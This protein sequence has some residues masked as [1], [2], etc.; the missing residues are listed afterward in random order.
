[1]AQGQRQIETSNKGSGFEVP[2]SPIGV[3]KV[4]SVGTTVTDLDGNDQE[5]LVCNLYS[6]DNDVTGLTDIAVRASSPG[7]HEVGDKIF[8]FRPDGGTGLTW[9]VGGDTEVQWIES[10]GGAK[11]VSGIDLFN[12]TSLIVDDAQ[13]ISAISGSSPLSISF[14]TDSYVDDNGVTIF[15]GRLVIGISAGNN[16]QVLSSNSGNV[17]WDWIRAH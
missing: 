5:I 13:Y 17:I 11:G 6:F 4:K 16:F 8:A 7:S 15:G 10:I 1:M 2:H 9:S 14:E 3:F 12:D